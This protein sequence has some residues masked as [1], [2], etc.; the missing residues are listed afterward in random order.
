MNV[1][2]R[3][4]TVELDAVFFCQSIRFRK[5]SGELPLDLPLGFSTVFSSK[6][7]EKSAETMSKISVAIDQEIGRAHV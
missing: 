4:K 3:V 2:M 7:S 6:E 5:L 1:L